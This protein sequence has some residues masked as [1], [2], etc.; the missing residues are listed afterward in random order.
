MLKNTLQVLAL[1]IAFCGAARAEEGGDVATAG[2]YDAIDVVEQYFGEPM[3]CSDA[4]R[5]AWFERELARS[6]GNPEADA[7]Y[8]PCPQEILADSSTAESD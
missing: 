4:R 6:E 2:G 8:G 1:L 3:S 7:A 5:T